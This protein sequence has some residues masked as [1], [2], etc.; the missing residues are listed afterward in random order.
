MTRSPFLTTNQIRHKWLTF[1]RRHDHFILPSVSLVPQ[2]DK[3]LLWVNAGITTI[4]Q[5]FTGIKQPPKTKLANIQKVI[6]TND[7]N[8][9]GKT[10]R[11][12]TVFE[13]LGNFSINSYFKKTAIK[14]AWTFLTSSEYLGFKPN[15]LYVT[16][17]AEDQVS[18]Q[19][20]QQQGLPLTHI[21]KGDKT[22][23]FWDI[24]VGPCGPCTEIFYDRGPKYDKSGFGIKALQENQESDR[25]LEIWNIVFSEQNHQANGL[26]TDLPTKNIDTGAGLERI[27]CIAQK[28]PTPF[29]TDEI[30]PIIEQAG[31]LVNRSFLSEREETKITLPQQRINYFLKVITDHM[32]AVTMAIG[33]GVD[34][35]SKKQAY[36]V[37]KLLRRSSVYGIFLGSG[38][39]FLYQL[40]KPIAIR[41]RASYPHLLENYKPIATK[42]K[43]EEVKFLATYHEAKK[44]WARMITNNQLSKEQAFLLISSYGLSLDIIQE[45]SAQQNVKVDFKGLQVLMVQHQQTSKQNNPFGNAWSHHL[46][47]ALQKGIKAKSVCY[48]QDTVKSTRISFILQDSTQGP[49]VWAPGAPLTSPLWFAFEETPFYPEGGGQVGDQGTFYLNKIEIKINDT[50]KEGEWILHRVDALPS[51][52]VNLIAKHAQTSLKE[53]QKVSF[54]EVNRNN[55]C[56]TRKNHTGT[57]LLHSALRWRFNNQAIQTG[58]FNNEK[59]LRLDV[60][61]RGVIKWSD[62]APLTKWVTNAINQAIPKQVHFSD[63]A[64]AITKHHALALFEDKYQSQVRTVQFGDLS[65]ELCGGTHCATTKEVEMMLITKFEKKGNHVYRFHA[66]TS[67]AN[68]IAEF[69][70]RWQEVALKL[71]AL[72][73]D[74]K[75]IKPDQIKSKIETLIAILQK[76]ITNADQYYKSYEQVA[77]LETEFK[78]WQKD[79]CQNQINAFLTELAKKDIKVHLDVNPATYHA[80]KQKAL[81]KIE[82]LNLKTFLIFGYFNRGKFRWEITICQPR[83]GFWSAKM[84]LQNLAA[85]HSVAFAQ[86]GG[87]NACQRGV[88]ALKSN[89]HDPQ[90]LKETL[91]RVLGQQENIKTKK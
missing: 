80:I 33:D 56:L 9:I 24:G 7:I 86:A 58:S 74:L 70:N 43:A 25:F 27:A 69:N 65:S 41:W 39:P 20:W 57:H 89:N 66:I 11:H 3:S 47:V 63:L 73:K 49:Q 44:V 53:G 71:K 79:E 84:L 64:T 35:G 46:K 55:R 48:H 16:V 13:M 87:S 12:L 88:L 5:Y 76:P 18:L 82:K 51:E 23:N 67:S 36:V 17:F 72:A 81:K 1:F 21:I 10:L 62:L 85:D 40:V 29:E 91:F 8:Q 30:L 38:V 68:V 4:K 2:T 45:L 59:G 22:T 54:L 90:A 6:R 78:R 31:L 52:V 75:K 26:Y 83:T 34:P 60:S 15:H 19:L 42:V 32:R 28:V 61:Y 37:R 77:S 14:M 50:K